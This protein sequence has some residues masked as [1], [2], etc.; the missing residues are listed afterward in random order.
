MLLLFCSSIE[1]NSTNQML[2][3]FYETASNIFP[4]HVFLLIH[5]I[6]RMPVCL[7]VCVLKW[8]AYI[9]FLYVC[10]VTVVVI[11]LFVC[12]SG[13]MLILCVC[14]CWQPLDRTLG[15]AYTHNDRSSLT[16]IAL[17]PDFF[18]TIMK[19]NQFSNTYAP[20]P[21]SLVT[22]KKYSKTQTIYHYFPASTTSAKISPRSIIS[23][24]T[25][26]L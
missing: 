11:C 16:M 8:C 3:T 18:I 6:C 4:S 10:D 13:A 21:N 24:L 9:V 14:V 20:S 15:N 12:D 22:L 25:A 19:S 7:F 26:F 2:Q 5:M 1:D 17:P 23:K